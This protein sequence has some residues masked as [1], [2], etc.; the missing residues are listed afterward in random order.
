[1]MISQQELEEWRPVV[2]LEGAFEVSSLGRVRRIYN[3]G[4]DGWRIMKMTPHRGGSSDPGRRYLIVNL[5]REGA[6]AI[7]RRYQ[8][9]DKRDSTGVQR[10][11]HLIVLEAFKGLRPT[12]GHQGLHNDS[13]PQNNRADNL[14]WGT[15]E[16]N[17]QDMVDHGTRKGENNGRSKLTAED[18]V[19]MR[20]R[21]RTGYHRGLYR[22][23]ARQYGV[24]PRMISY[25]VTGVH[26][27]HL[28]EPPVKTAGGA[29]V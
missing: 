25:A 14:R 26:W 8:P 28:D 20:R 1:M 29:P 3:G 10:A 16:E 24:H 22:E 19:A 12:P 4:V 21:V 11:V 17:C 6:R 27:G 5:Q 18:V 13:N 2:G 9:G 7:G 15:W 23:L